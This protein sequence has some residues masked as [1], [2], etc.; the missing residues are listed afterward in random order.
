MC[1]CLYCVRGAEECGG[2][3]SVSYTSS[4]LVTNISTFTCSLIMRLSNELVYNGALKCGS[5]AVANQRITVTN[6]QHAMQVCSK[7][8]LELIASVPLPVISINSS[9]WHYVIT[10]WCVEYLSSISI[11][12]DCISLTS[13]V[14]KL[15]MVAMVT[16]ISQSW[17]DK[18][19]TSL[20]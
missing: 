20:K 3:L 17:P 8:K 13:W 15:M 19:M 2:Y 10:S 1:G 6:W 14:T 7:K 12:L 16:E 11:I 4:F 5:A 18:S 9:G